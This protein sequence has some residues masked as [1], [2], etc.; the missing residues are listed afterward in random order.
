MSLHS[1]T[2][3]TTANF[4]ERNVGWATVLLLLIGCMLVLRPFVSAM[5]WAIIL[6][7]TTWP[8]YRRLLNLM[9]NRRTLAALVMSLALTLIL[10]L[11]FFIIGYSLAD[12][13]KDLVQATNNWIATG[14]KEPPP[15]VEKLPVV[16]SAAGDYWRTL[17]SDSAK[18]LQEA[19][20]WLE[21]L[22]SLALKIGL[23]L[24]SGVLE[25]ALSIFTAF[26]LFR[27]GVAAAEWLNTGMERLGGSRARHLL[28][29]AGNTVRGVVYGILGTAM[30]QALM[31]GV[32]FF[33]AGVPGAAL[34]ALLTF[35]LSVLPVG[36][37]L[38][39]IPATFWLFH[40]HRPGW[41]VFMLIW[42]IGVSSIDNILK[43]WLIS[44]GNKMPFLLIFFGVLGGALAFGFIGVFLGPTLLAVGYRV[45][46]EWITI[47]PKPLAINP[48]Q[49]AKQ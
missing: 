8:L 4:W 2:D 10:L 23:A 5:L 44:Q 22:S 46:V 25:L 16:G 24:G 47:T 30:A 37:P 40:I 9:G 33:I 35:F 38:I 17:A 15:W 32:G 19:K 48:E 6:C 26:F 3:P 41:A 31:A 42:G 49:P 27:D 14:L 13:V 11:P 1:K 7:F 18:R 28:E 34:L 43:P 29:V 12:N 20:R 39:W 21:P 45:V 36:P